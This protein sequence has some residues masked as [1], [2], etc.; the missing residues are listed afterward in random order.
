MNNLESQPIIDP[1]K[2][3]SDPATMRNLLLTYTEKVITLENKVL[4]QAPKVKAFDRIASADGLVNLQTAGK[5][6]QQKPN[7]FIQK[8]RE[9]RWIFKRP[10]AKDNSAYI[11]KINAGYLAT[12]SQEYEKPDGT[13]HISD[14]VMVTPLI[15][16]VRKKAPAG[17]ITTSLM[18]DDVKERLMDAAILVGMLYGSCELYLPDDASP[19]AIEAFELLEHAVSIASQYTVPVEIE[20]DEPV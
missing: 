11:D 17:R 3:L 5:I 4:E 16:T 1:M 2:A 9:I 13:I 8:L 19:E 15:R 7:K 20:V 12:K 6:L 18:P 14:Q 10:G